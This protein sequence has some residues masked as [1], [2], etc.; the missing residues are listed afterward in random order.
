[1]ELIN[2]VD[3]MMELNN[4]VDTMMELNNS[5]VKDLFTPLKI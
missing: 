2:S 1:M 5:M 4:S 3:T